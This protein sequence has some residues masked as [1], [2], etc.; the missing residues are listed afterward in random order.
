MAQVMPPPLSPTLPAVTKPVSLRPSCLGKRRQSALVE[1]DLKKALTDI[2]DAPSVGK[3]SL[4]EQSTNCPSLVSTA[5]SSESPSRR[6]SV[7]RGSTPPGELL[8]LTIEE[9]VCPSP[10]LPSPFHNFHSVSARATSCLPSMCQEHTLSESTTK[11]ALSSRRTPRRARQRIKAEAKAA[12]SNPRSPIWRRASSVDN[13][14]LSLP[15][16]E[17][18]Y[19]SVWELG[20]TAGRHVELSNCRQEEIR[21]EARRVLSTPLRC[22]RELSTSTCG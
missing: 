20:R 5:V 17:V 12:M 9:A 15:C 10:S 8:S 22:T 6:G 16:V 18:G 11:R 2:L 21:A 14:A 1:Q 19:W 7:D 13:R 4:S 3:E